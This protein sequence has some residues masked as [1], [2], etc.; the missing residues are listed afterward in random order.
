MRLGSVWKRHFAASEFFVVV[1]V[2]SCVVHC[3]T[4][5]SGRP[6]LSL[7]AE[8]VCAEPLIGDRGGGWGLDK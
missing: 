8:G 7:S 4:R 6:A 2:V 3:A 5:E 1:V